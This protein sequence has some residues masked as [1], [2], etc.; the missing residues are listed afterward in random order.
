M[1]RHLTFDCNFVQQ[2]ATDFESWAEEQLD[3]LRLDQQGMRE[4]AEKQWATIDRIREERHK[5]N[6]GIGCPLLYLS[7]S[8]VNH[9][10]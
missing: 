9:L 4:R 3:K 5:A 7:F 10:Y 6:L 2:Q 8:A 1:Q